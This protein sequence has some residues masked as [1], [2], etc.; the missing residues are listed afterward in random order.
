MAATGAVPRLIK[1]LKDPEDLVKLNVLKTI[2]CA[3][4]HPQARK[5]CV[6]S[7]ECLLVIEQ[8]CNGGDEFLASSSA[9][10][11]KSAK[12]WSASERVS[13]VAPEPTALLSRAAF[14]FFREVCI[15]GT[16]GLV[17]V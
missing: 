17:N 12:V 1:L 2:T 8:I 15:C 10:A 14:R 11:M 6:E 13:V 16:K 7:S 4:V 3:A 9:R 5:E